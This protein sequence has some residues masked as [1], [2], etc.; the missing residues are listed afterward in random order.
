[1]TA[2]SIKAPVVIHYVLDIRPKCE[3]LGRN[4]AKDISFGSI[5]NAEARVKATERGEL[6]VSIVVDVVVSHPSWCDVLDY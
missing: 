5:T 3:S 6:P 2:S 4:A 1:M